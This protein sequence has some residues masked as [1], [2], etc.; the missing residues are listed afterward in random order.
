MKANDSGAL[1]LGP[2]EWGWSGFFYSGYD[3]QWGGAHGWSNLPDR[4]AHGNMDYMPWLLQNLKSYDTANGTKSIDIFSLHWYPQSG[5]FSNDDSAGMQLN[6]NKST[7]SLWDPAYTD[8]SWF[9]QNR[10]VD[11]VAAPTNP[12]R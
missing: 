6:R 3:L 10:L 9:F 11:H 8:I 5:E 4:T 12:A 1:V 2:E 7:R